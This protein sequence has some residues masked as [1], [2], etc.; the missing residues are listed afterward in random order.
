[1]ALSDVNLLVSNSINQL[2]FFVRLYF[3]IFQQNS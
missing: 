2:Q 1:M 3:K